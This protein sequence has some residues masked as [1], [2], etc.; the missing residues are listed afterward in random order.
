MR[1]AISPYHQALK[2]SLE[3]LNMLVPCLLVEVFPSQALFDQI[4]H[5]EIKLW[6]G[7][8]RHQVD[9]TQ[10]VVQSIKSR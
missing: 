1:V 9:Q 6:S 7:L 3:I 8:L 4:L 5:L 2:N 10:Q